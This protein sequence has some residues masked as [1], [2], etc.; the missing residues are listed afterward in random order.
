MTV[1]PITYRSATPFDAP[2]IAE[3]HAHS[4]QLHYR[5]AMPDDYLDR[6]APAERLTVWTDRFSADHENMR[7]LLAEEDDV[8]AGFCCIVLGEDD[9]DGTLLDN[10]H[11][12]P[13][14]QGSGVGKRLMHWA[15]KETLAYAPD[16]E[17]Y[18]WVLEQNQPAMDVYLHLGG[19]AGRRERK[20]LVATAP[21]GVTAVAIH[22]DP[23]DL[24]DRTAG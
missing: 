15:A 5:G 10:L 8:L 3:L 14:Y 2:R 18:L 4:W 24:R 9:Q 22:F 19:Q 20:H 12:R 11:V 16:G 23:A 17:L 6:E 13:G 21:E 7:V 1:P